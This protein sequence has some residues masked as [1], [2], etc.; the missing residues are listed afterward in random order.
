MNDELLPDVVLPPPSAGPRRRIRWPRVAVAALLLAAVGGVGVVLASHLPSTFAAAG[1]STPS[2]ANWADG[3]A[4]EHRHGGPGHDLTV[5]SVSGTTIIAKDESGASVTIHTSSS[6]MVQRAG[7]SITLS[8]L[9]AG[10]PIEVRGARNSDGTI[11]AS[12]IDVALPVYAGTVTKMSGNTITVQSP[13]DNATQTIV[14]S[15]S[16]RYTRAGSS[17]SLSDVQ[18]GS[19]IAAEGAVNSDKSLA[20]ERVDVEVPHVDGQITSVSGSTITL[21]DREG[22]TVT[23]HTT[24]ST[25]AASVSIGANG[26]MRSSIALSSLKV[27]DQISVEGTRNSDGSL[28]ALSVTLLPNA[29]SGHDSAGGPGFGDDG[30]GDDMGPAA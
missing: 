22:G 18:V 3:P 27:G 26:P 9:T 8:D 14:V 23:V 13:R 11:T 24:A 25:N 2:A 17:A 19:I 5:S 6:T 20:A 4:G 12:E 29:P 30:P 16:T 7:V 21:R 15:S 1:Q 10:T 28:T